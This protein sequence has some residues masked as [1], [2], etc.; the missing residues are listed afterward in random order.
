MV[1]SSRHVDPLTRGGTVRRAVPGVTAVLLTAVL[2]VGEI[3]ATGN[4]RAADRSGG[5]RRRTDRLLGA[6]ELGST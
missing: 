5:P 1:A 4:Y 6:G 3:V 2:M